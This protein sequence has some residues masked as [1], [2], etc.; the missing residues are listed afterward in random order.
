MSA[1]SGMAANLENIGGRIMV[2]SE[3]VHHKLRMKEVRPSV[4]TS[5]PW[6]HRQNSAGSAGSGARVAQRLREA[7]DGGAER[8]WTSAGGSGGSSRP[9]S[10]HL[11]HGSAHRP[12]SATGSAAVTTRTVSPHAAAGFDV[13]SLSVEQQRVY[14]DMVRMLCSLEQPQCKQLLEHMYREAEDKKL[15]MAYTGVFPEDTPSS[16]TK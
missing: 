4:D 11:H 7:A 6:A 14:R 5:K 3:M 15:L 10:A 12:Q 16:D 9:Q 1:A 13:S 2:E 8:L